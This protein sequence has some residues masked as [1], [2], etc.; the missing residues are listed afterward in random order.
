MNN[1]ISE[2][3]FANSNWQYFERAIGRYFVHRGWQYVDIVGESGD[4]GADI[5]ASHDGIDYVI[6]VKYSKNNKKL[7]VDIVGDVIRAMDFYEINKGFCIS[8]RNLGEAQK[9]KLKGFQNSGYDI[10]SFTGQ[11]LID[12]LKNLPDW[13]DDPR[14]PKNYQLE[15]I[16]KLKESYE[17]NQTRGLISLATGMGKTFVACSF[18]KW[19]YKTDKDLNIV[20]LAHQEELLKQFERSL[21]TSLP[22]YIS[23]HLL[24]SDVKPAFNG[25]V[26]LSTFG[27]F[28][29]WYQKRE[30]LRFDIAVVDEAHHSRARTYERVINLVDAGYLLGLTATPYRADGLDVTEL[31]GP[32]LVYYN[33]ARGIRNRF[34]S[35]VDYRLRCDNM[36]K[37][38][39]QE[40]SLKGYTI[41]QLNKK[42]FIKDREEHVC[43]LIYNYFVNE[44]RKRAVIFCQGVKHADLIK[45]LLKTNFNLPCG[46]ITDKYDKKTNARKLRQFRNG[47]LK[48]I[49]TVDML[50]E[51]VDVPDIDFICF[52]RVTHSRTYFLQQLGRGLRYQ[53]NKTLLVIDFVADLRRIKAVQRQK[54]EYFEDGD[55]YME[56]E[57][58]FNL[59]FSNDFTDNFLTLVSDEIE[60]EFLEENELIE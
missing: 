48:V 55:E 26:L 23:T 2:Q 60:N 24:T 40:N 14:V 22:K 11:R 5:I 3:V 25:G 21:W 31:F 6:Q 16:E 36:D 42:L 19:L 13:A 7:S 10:N 50:N 43:E 45:N 28:T 52:L 17:L 4:M 44:N 57:T 33:V 15:S 9:I 53:D 12:S 27:V 38:W 35:E 20:I 30:D 18:I 56:L 58:G 59:T 39:I 37:D 49:T 8:N 34:L 29:D 46:V 54:D 47:Q 51:G 32:P 41:K 1:F